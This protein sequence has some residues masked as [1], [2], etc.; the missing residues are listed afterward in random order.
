MNKNYIFTLLVTLLFSVF[1]FGQTPIITMISDG[2]CTGG[3]PKV[4]E[5]YAQGTVDFALYSLENQTNANATWGNALDLSALGTV[6]DSYVYIYKSTGTI[7]ADEFPSVG[8]NKLEDSGST[9]SFN[10]D[11]R[12]RIIKTSDSTVIDQYGVEAEDGTGKPWEYKDG[13]SK[14]NPGTAPNGGT[15]VAANWAFNNGA[16][17]NQGTCQGGATFESIIGLATYAVTDPTITITSPSNGATI[18][19]TNTV[20]ISVSVANFVVGNPGDAGVDGHI[21]WT[22]QE[23][24]DAP[25]NQPMKYNTDD[26]AITVTPGNSYTVTMTLADNSHAPIVPNVST[27]V[28]FSVELPC[29]LVL[30]SISTTCDAITTGTDTFTGAIAF[31]GGNTGVTY[32]IT[33]A[34][35]TVSGDNPST[36]GS[37]VI[38]VTGLTEGEDV[39][40]TIVGDAT[41]SCNYTRTLYSPTCVAFPI[42]ETFDY[43]VGTD[44]TDAPN[45]TTSSTS[46]DKVKVVAASIN[47][48]YNSTEFPNPTGNMVNFAGG[49][50]DP[51][52]EFNQQDS[53]TIYASFIFTSTDMTGIQTTGGYFAVLQESAGS[54]K[55]RLWV[56]PDTGDVAKFNIGVSAGSS[57]SNYSSNVYVTGEE[58]FIVMAYEFATNEIKVWINPDPATFEGGVAPTATL[59]E[60]GGTATN[61]G[62]FLLRQDSTNETPPIN[63]DELRIGTTWKQVTPKGVTASVRENNIAGFTVYPNPVNNHKVIITTASIEKK[64]V[65]IFNVLGRKVFT[66]SFNGLTKELNISELSKGIYI[67][68][69]I[70]GN[71][72]AT[73]KLVVK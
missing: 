29:D 23:N 4:L 47:N 56:R 71:N 53:G 59:T 39:S 72:T 8:A 44:L 40:V 57:A 35:G 13:Y 12:I 55:A 65:S 16:L 54:Y 31:T 26:E 7:F 34:S 18:A 66:Q 14:R 38:T 62:R 30:G 36:V 24:T 69:I 10:G 46:T 43:A 60:T 41:S 50:A 68:K 11:D 15:F 48:P 3:N 27:S 19:A 52:I 2:D 20:N 61:L 22:V 33:A 58:A 63:F 1:S 17:N 21:H 32:T 51:Y 70:E 64:S 49:G 73:K 45:W 5:I 25:V 9:M 28:T 42:I 6:T 67:L 37:G